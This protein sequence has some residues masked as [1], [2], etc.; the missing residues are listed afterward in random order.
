MTSMDWPIHEITTA[1]R[2]LINETVNLDAIKTKMVR[3][4]QT[5]SR[6]VGQND[7][8]VCLKGDRFDAHQFVSDVTEQGALAVITDR[9]VQADI[10]QWVVQDT[11]KAIGLLARN[12]RSRFSMP[13][14]AVVGS[15]GKTTSKEMLRCVAQVALESNEFCITEGNLNNEIGVPLTLFRLRSVHRFAVIEM[16]MN[17]PGEIAQLAE[18]VK[19]NSVLLTNAQRE[20]QEFMKTVAFVAQENGSAFTWLNAEGVAVFPAGT[21]F[22]SLWCDQAKGRK[23]IRFGPL[24]NIELSPDS[25]GAMLRFGQQTVPLKPKFIGEHNYSNASGVAAVSRAVGFSQQQIIQGLELFTPVQGR[26]Q[27]VCDNS[28]IKL[29]DDT[30]NANPDSVN[31]AS[32]YLASLNESTILVLGDMGEVGDQSHNYHREVGA[33]AKELG[34]DRMFLLGEETRFTAEG[35]GEGAQHFEDL[36]A[37][38]QSL[39]DT[40][41][42]QKYTVLVKG[43]RFMRMERV[44]EAL[45]VSKANEPSQGEPHV[46]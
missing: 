17:H 44:I 18:M 7:L 24:G 23:I 14:V 46:A 8:F 16:G 19:P 45:T 27:L 15:N 22:D 33:F 38:V 4:V 6:Q 2:P 40:L 41:C 31:A 11:R 12:W 1:L 5:D 9:P 39:K 37:L 13:V 26:F 21:L 10:A 3:L 42:H 34:V 32:Q 28:E 36:G 43:S 35:F 25:E 20:H 30:Y 29:I